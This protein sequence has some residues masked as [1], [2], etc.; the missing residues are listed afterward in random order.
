MQIVV[1]E[2]H[3]WR[4]VTRVNSW[5]LWKF[6]LRT[7]TSL[8]CAGECLNLSFFSVSFFELFVSWICFC[9]HTNNAGTHCHL[10]SIWYFSVL[11]NIAAP[12]GSLTDIIW[13]FYCCNTCYNCQLWVEH[14]SF[15]WIWLLHAYYD[16]NSIKTRLSVLKNQK[17]TPV[18]SRATP[19]NADDGS[20]LSTLKM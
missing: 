13:K 18:L 5:Y 9:A 14:C 11:K 16:V 17:K 8:M 15:G 3:N 20:V 10:S 2:I 6:S 7:S 19:Q 4:I 1:P 12:H